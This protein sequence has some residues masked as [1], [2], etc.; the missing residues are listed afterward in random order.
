MIMLLNS[1]ERCT[2]LQTIATDRQVAQSAC[3]SFRKFSELHHLRWPPF[4]AACP[5]CELDLLDFVVFEIDR[6][7]G[8]PVAVKGQSIWT[9][10]R[11]N[12]TATVNF[13]D[14]LRPGKRF[15]DRFPSG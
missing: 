9:Q 6:L 3:T 7:V 2:G 8:E 5:A 14:L 11:R 12:E 4:R 15:L 10:R 13:R 1:Q